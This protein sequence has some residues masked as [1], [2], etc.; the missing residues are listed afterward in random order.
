M[1]RC[2]TADG[3]DGVKRLPIHQLEATGTRDDEHYLRGDGTWATVDPPVIPGLTVQDENS[4]VSTDVTKLDFQGAGVTV[5][6]GT[7]EVVVTIPGAT[8]S[9]GAGEVLMQDGVT[10]PPVPIETEA[11]DDWLYQD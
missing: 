4:D 7:G 5:T 6:P 3:G 10:A 9:S 8:S 1:D 11:Q 2:D